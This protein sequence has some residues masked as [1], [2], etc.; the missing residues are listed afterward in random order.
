[1]PFVVFGGL[2]AF[3][4]VAPERSELQEQ[5]GRSVEQRGRDAKPFRY[6][7]DDEVYALDLD[8]R[9]VRFGLLEGWDREQDAYQDSA[10]LA[11]VSGP[12]Y[13][14]H[15]DD[16]GREITVPWGISNSAS[17]FGAGVTA[18]LHANGPSSASATTAAL[19]SATG[20]SPMSAAAPT[21]PSSVACTAFT[22]TSRLR[23]RATRGPT[24]SAWAS[25]FA[26]TCRGSAW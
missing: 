11:Y 13:E 21:T 26:T 1:M 25:A 6:I 15:V 7:P 10:A 16:D 22:T 20:S 18:R 3:A 17:R 2:I 8:P 5:A 19:I 24:A 14:R 12:M 4:P 23:R 9:R